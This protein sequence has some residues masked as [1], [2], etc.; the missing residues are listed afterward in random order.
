MAESIDFTP[1]SLD[2]DTI[3]LQSQN[4]NQE[5]LKTGSSGIC[6]TSSSGIG[7]EEKV[8]QVVQHAKSWTKSNK[9]TVLTSDDVIPQI[10]WQCSEISDRLSCMDSDML[11]L[12]YSFG[13]DLV[14]QLTVG[15]AY[16]DSIKYWWENLDTLLSISDDTYKSILQF[17]QKIT[18]V[19]IIFFY[20]CFF[21]FFVNV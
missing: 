16:Y 18:K 21:F 15:N 14:K 7:L 11:H 20:F 2:Y 8:E 12:K 5:Q 3:L 13:I 4:C 9:N 17:C 19:S 10:L 6:L 1:Q